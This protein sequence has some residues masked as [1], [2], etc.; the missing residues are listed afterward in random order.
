MSSEEIIRKLREMHIGNLGI[1]GDYQ[2]EIIKRVLAMERK[3][4]LI[5]K[6]LEEI[7]NILKKQN[8]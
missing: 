8:G 3:L 7:E 6:K 4:D 2:L 1:Y 5:I